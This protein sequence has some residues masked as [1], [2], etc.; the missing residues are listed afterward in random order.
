MLAFSG[1]V[2]G[3]KGRGGRRRER[4]EINSWNNTNIH[5]GTEELWGRGMAHPVWY[6][7]IHTKRAAI[8]KEKE[9]VLWKTR[10]PAV[11]E[12]YVSCIG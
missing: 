7:T 6:L 1:E 4:G 11:L 10:F 5:H 2:A 12:L 8:T 9:P 3:E